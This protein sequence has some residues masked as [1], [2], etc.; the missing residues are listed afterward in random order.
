MRRSIGK[1]FPPQHATL[2]KAHGRIEQRTIRTTT[3]LN[4]YLDFPHI[5]QAA[6]VDRCVCDRHTDTPSIERAYL[7]TDLSPQQ[8][9]PAQLLALNRGHWQIENRLHWV[10]DVTFDEDRSQVRKGHGPQVLAALRNFVLT[11]LRRIIK[12]PRT[13]I[14]SALRYFAAR[15]DQA[16]AVLFA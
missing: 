10:R 7:I 14:A 3:A 11:L 8:A 4:H 5:G 16:L 15:P 6:A 1:R 13:S 9:S 2:D 12:R